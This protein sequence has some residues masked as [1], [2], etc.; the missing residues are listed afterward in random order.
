MTDPKDPRYL[1]CCECC[2]GMFFDPAGEL[3]WALQRGFQSESILCPKCIVALKESRDDLRN[4][5]IQ[6]L[7]DLLRARMRVRETMC[8]EA[9]LL[10]FMWIFLHTFIGAGDSTTKPCGCTMAKKLTGDGCEICNPAKAMELAKE[11]IV[12]LALANKR[13]LE[14]LKS[15]ASVKDRAKSMRKGGVSITWGVAASQMYSLARKAIHRE[16]E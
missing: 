5:R 11:T 10:Q 9:K 3:H 1:S 8:R 2:E 16:T 4:K 6:A 7:K 15:I 13:M 14:A 12:D